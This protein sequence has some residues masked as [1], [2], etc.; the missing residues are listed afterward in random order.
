MKIYL[1]THDSGRRKRF[2]EVISEDETEIVDCK[3]CHRNY[4]KQ[5]LRNENLSAYVTNDY[6]ADFA[7][8]RPSWISEKCKNILFSENISGFQTIKVEML[9]YKDI[10]KE[11]ILDLKR[12]GYKVESIPE[13]P[14]QYYNLYCD[15]SASLH[16]ESNYGVIEYCN[17]CGYEVFGVLS[18]DKEIKC[19]LDSSSLNSNDIFNVKGK[20]T[21]LFCNE[22]FKEVVE[23]HNLMGLMFEEIEVK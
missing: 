6:Y 16:L 18:S 11:E 22:R 4:M 5:I 2:A 21:T 14:I 10:V 1:I 20:G 23:N 19:V 9:S 7:W 3:T 12:S 15:Y 8:G 13:N 17:E